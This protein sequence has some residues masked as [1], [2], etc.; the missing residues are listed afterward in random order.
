MEMLNKNEI[1]T[2]IDAIEDFMADDKAVVDETYIHQ[3]YKLNIYPQII[4]KLKS[5]CALTFFS[6]QEYTLI[7]AALLYVRK[8]DDSLGFT[9]ADLCSAIAKISPLAEPKQNSLS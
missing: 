7:L 5:Y 2:C 9:D 8:L 3:D 1:E 4:K 6:V